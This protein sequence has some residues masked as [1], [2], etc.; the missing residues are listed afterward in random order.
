MAGETAA[1]RGASKRKVGRPSERSRR[2]VRARLG[3]AARELFARH[4]FEAVSLRQ[5]AEASGVT[6]AMVHYYFGGKQG[7]WLA[8]LEDYL[9]EALGSMLAARAE[10]EGP[11]G[12]DVYLARHAELLGRQ[13][14]VAPLLFRELILGGGPSADFVQ[15]FPAQLRD[16]LRSAVRQAKRRGE[17]ARE[18]DSD[19]LV[20][21]LLSAAVFP[22][23]VRPIAEQ[24]FD[25]P[26]DTAFAS[27]W[28]AHAA[29]IFHLGAR[30]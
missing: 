25:A 21:S 8:V 11:G 13:P 12:L 4:G 30:P 5:V 29:R 6:P 19:L 22:F 15:R 27:R 7:L 26:I 28:S 14:W 23:L 2:E 3:A 9:E 24:L 10:I 18:L 17:I 20:L 16:L 1:A